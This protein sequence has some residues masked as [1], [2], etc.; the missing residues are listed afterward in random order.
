MSEVNDVARES[1]HFRDVEWQSLWRTYFQ[2]I[3]NVRTCDGRQTDYWWLHSHVGMGKEQRVRW[4]RAHCINII[5]FGSEQNQ[6]KAGLPKNFAI[7][8]CL[9]VWVYGFWEE[10][11]SHT[12]NR[13]I[14]ALNLCKVKIRFHRHKE[15]SGK[16]TRTKID[17]WKIMDS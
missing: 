8:N 7:L 13:L 4:T 9:L 11:L 5:N 6:Q 2:W 17:E 16:N 10:Q 1:Q 3:Q 12:A 15:Q 14:V